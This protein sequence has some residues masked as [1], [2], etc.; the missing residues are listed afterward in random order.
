MNSKNFNFIIENNNET[1]EKFL[2]ISHNWQFS[3]QI[4]GAPIMDGIVG[5]H[6]L[7]M[8]YLVFIVIFVTIM[9]ISACVMFSEEKMEKI[10]NLRH[11]SAVEAS[12]TLSAIFILFMMASVS[13]SLLYSSDEMMETDLTVKVI[14]KQW[15]WTYEQIIQNIASMEVLYGTLFKYVQL[16]NDSITTNG[17]LTKLTDFLKTIINTSENK[18][19]NLSEDFYMMSDEEI[20]NRKN[21]IFGILSKLFDKNEI[22]NIYIPEDRL[23][24]TVGTHSDSLILPVRTHIRFLITSEDVIHS[25]AIPSLGIKMDAIPGRINQIFTYI[26]YNG[27]YYGQ[28]SELCGVNHGF[29]PI[30]IK[31]ISFDTFLEHYFKVFIKKLI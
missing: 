19:F 10:L 18:Y 23:L 31:A 1:V 11:N 24:R 4:P 9:L 12:S 27:T 25:W 5:L 15:Y 26:P 22:N 2:G 20:I 30:A 8:V 3:F 17:D 14:G 13:F 7:L 28:C 6:N 21:S 29:M 16:S